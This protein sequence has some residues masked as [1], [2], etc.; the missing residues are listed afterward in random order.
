M[1]WLQARQGM[2]CQT[3]QLLEEEMYM[4]KS[5]FEGQSSYGSK[6][7]TLLQVPILPHG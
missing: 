7:S 6:M 2:C 4:G 1:E 5:Q 3:A